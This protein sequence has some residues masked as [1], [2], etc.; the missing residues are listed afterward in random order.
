MN[1]EERRELY[2]ALADFYGEKNQCLLCI[3]EM[4]ELTKELLKFERG[5]LNY[6]QI[7]EEVAD[8]TITLEQVVNIYNISD[9]VQ[10]YREKK[11]QRT[12]GRLSADI[13]KYQEINL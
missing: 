9:D 7:A 6:E 8:V 11:L 5:F 12:A 13:E 1:E 2:Q 3:E 4:A 10:K